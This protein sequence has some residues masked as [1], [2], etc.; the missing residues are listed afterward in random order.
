MIAATTT[1]NVVLTLHQGFSRVVLIYSAL[2]AVWGLLLYVRGSNPSGGYL[3]A[4][5]LDWGVVILQG[6]IGIALVLQGHR[7]GDS[8]HFLYGGV[9]FLTL[10]SAYLFSEH[11]A[12]RRDSLV[13]GLATL[14]LVGI[15]IRAIGTGG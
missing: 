5:I 9:A 14:F 3:G 7:P 15:S 12:Q 8:L 1:S 6:I 11:G 13:F 4:L 10:P 2:M